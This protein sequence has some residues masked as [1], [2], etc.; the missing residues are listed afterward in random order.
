MSTHGFKN[1]D[2]HLYVKSFKDTVPPSTT[3]NRSTDDKRKQQIFTCNLCNKQY[4][5]LPSLHRHQLQCNDKKSKS[6]HDIYAKEF[7]MPKKLQKSLLKVCPTDSIYQDFKC[8][9]CGNKYAWLYS[10][11]RHQLQCGNK[12]PK[13]KCKFCPKKFYRQDRF[14]Q[15]LIIYH[16]TSKKNMR[17]L[18]DQ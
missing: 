8:D 2:D 6:K 4:T 12:E 3:P 16:K 9:L 18:K 7:H 14:Q 10:L 13:Y 1:R 5:F 11:R 15:H 17:K